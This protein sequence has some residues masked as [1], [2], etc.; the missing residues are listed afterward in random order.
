[1][2]S[3]ALINETLKYLEKNENGQPKYRFDIYRNGVAQSINKATSLLT[4]GVVN[5]A[6]AEDKS[7]PTPVSV[8]TIGDIFSTAKN[9]RGDAATVFQNIKNLPSELDNVKASLKQLGFNALDKTIDT[10]KAAVVPIEVIQTVNSIYRVARPLVEKVVDIASIMFHFENAAKV[11]Q[12]VLQYLSRLAVSTARNYLNRLWE[13]FLDT[14]V[15]A[16]YE[17]DETASL[18]GAYALL[19]N[20]A[21]NVLEALV[22]S[23]DTFNDM[24]TYINSASDKKMYEPGYNNLGI[25]IPD[26]IVDVYSDPNTRKIFI[27][28]KNEIYQ[29]NE[30]Y[31]ITIVTTSLNDISKVFYYNGKVYFISDNNIYEANNDNPWTLTSPTIVYSNPLLVYSDGEF[32]NPEAPHAL[33]FSG[34]LG[35][36]K[37][38]AFDNVRGILY[39]ISN[40][41][42]LMMVSRDELGNYK[43]T[44]SELGPVSSGIKS[45]V[46]FNNFLYVVIGNKVEKINAGMNFD[47]VN[48]TGST[49]KITNI[50]SDFAVDGTYIYDYSIS[51]N[52]VVISSPKKPSNSVNCAIKKTYNGSNYMFATGG[53]TIG[54]SKNNGPWF[55]KGFN[56]AYIQTGSGDIPD[57]F[58]GC[59]W[60]YSNAYGDFLIKTDTA[61][62]IVRH[63]DFSVWRLEKDCR[64]GHWVEVE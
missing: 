8:Y 63:S 20:E 27:A 26:D 28:S 41:N 24:L 32:Y 13:L 39:Y 58:A 49:M 61:T 18:S 33:V 34:T 36:N 19:S 30:D 38:T 17:N 23:K 29:L 55:N 5:D 31:S 53:M 6:A 56:N 59:N 43:T 3:K 22:N 10:I 14:P 48:Y 54:I 44:P 12:D 37:L 62:Y 21:N 4:A 35:T 11:A 50:N 64:W 60:F 25:T 45:M 15:F 46:Y 57:N 42:K 47:R 7:A 40:N 2:D 16:V 51:S 1:M 9:V 52:S